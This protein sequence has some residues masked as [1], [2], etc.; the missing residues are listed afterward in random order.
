MGGLFIA[1][2]L[3][4][5]AASIAGYLFV[6]PRTSSQG[7]SAVGCALALVVAPSWLFLRYDESIL[8]AAVALALT[9]LSAVGLWK[10][11]ASASVART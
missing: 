9:V 4:P 8:E 7:V 10:A 2:L 3:V 5:V 1:L 6:R 11:R